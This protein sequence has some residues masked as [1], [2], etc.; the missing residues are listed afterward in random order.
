M[1]FPHS[2]PG[3]RT[4]EDVFFAYYPRLLEWATQ[5]TR[6]DRS[7]AE[8]LVHDFYLRLTRIT[9]SIDGMEQLEHYLFRVLRNL[10]YSRLRRAGR[11]PLNDLSIVDYDSVEHGLESADRRQVLFVRDHLR[12]ICRYACERKSN[13]RSASVLILRFFLGYYPTEVMKIL[14][15]GRSSVD[16]LLQVA[17]NE[18]RLSLERPEAIR[19]IAPSAKPSLSFHSRGDSTQQLFAE[20]QEAIFSATEGECFDPAVLEQRY[21]ADGD[22]A[23]LT[24]RELSHLVSCRICLDR[25]N[26]ILHLPL[27]ADRSPED[28]IDRDSASG[29]GGESGAGTGKLGGRKKSLKKGPSI[30]KL[31]RRARE[32]HEHRPNS[33]Q[34][35]VDGDV[36][37][38]QK[39]TAEI[40]E[41]RLKLAREDEPSFIEVLSEQGF[42]MAFL[43]VDEPV[44]ADKLEQVESTSFS[45]DRSLILTLS[46]DADGP[47]VHVLYRDPVMVEAATGEFSA[48]PV[49]DIALADKAQSAVKKLPKPI[50]SRPHNQFRGETGNW[51]TRIAGRIKALFIDDMNPMLA[52]AMICAVTSIVLL[53]LSF[54]AANVMK[55]NDLLQRA[56]TSENALSQ[57]GASGVV[58]QTVRIRTPQRKVERTLY[59]DVQRK[60]RLKEQKLSQEDA[61]LRTNLEAVGIGWNDPLSAGSFRDWHDHANIQR[62]VVKRP[63]KGLLT[64]TTTLSEGSIASESLTVREIDFRPVE[65]TVELRD[66]GTVEIAELNYSVLPWSSVNPDLFEAVF[67]AAGLG[68]HMHSAILPH[69]PRSVS[70]TEMDEAELGV[71]LV[72]SHLHLDSND[73][74][75]LTRQPVGVHVEGVVD[76]DD[77]KRQLQAQLHMVPHVSASILTIQEM[78]ARP[79]AAS[80]VT[81]IQQSSAT[82]APAPSALERYFA[83]RGM[84]RTAAGASVQEFALSSFAVRRQSEQIT[85][86]LGRFSSSEKLSDA[87]R[88]ELS[89]LLIQHKAALVDALGREDRQLAILQ[90]T[91]QSA[92]AAGS[93]HG[94]AD[95]LTEIAESN[96]A[97]CTELVS[98]NNASSHTAQ[99]IA[100]QLAD[101]IAQLRTVVLRIS[102]AAQLSSPSSASL[103]TANQNK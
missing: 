93:V 36:R 84:D 13:V 80:D 96:F 60:R 14:R 20:L 28:G 76:D 8:D 71:R 5:I 15:S 42:C 91:S 16:M 103:A 35:V 32:L 86:L 53:F 64:L 40:N 69:L 21:A 102:A 58:V 82:A 90:L 10:Y 59:R 75:E 68:R 23:G 30:R 99:Q 78:A 79:A 101:S 2:Q 29:S 33:L 26:T 62:D 85:D 27:L 97:L 34:I 39:V 95:A 61:A 45:D 12:E 11:D 77:K 47:I 3:R 72:L 92:T 51:I 73:R 100:P 87:A 52:T 43:L 9:R 44:S 88:A 70:P 38:L 1:T 83:D 66:A 49:S 56:A 19:C 22:Q 57:S 63:E 41:L 81:S 54:R 24:T 65:R 50:I 37:T 48:K 6:N 18:A 7:E 25:V 89:E 17:R 67:D 74:I 4:N 46:F 98:E 31:E 94:S 55:P